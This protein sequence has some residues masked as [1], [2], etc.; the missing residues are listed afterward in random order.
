MAQ[1]TDIEGWGVD[2]A[3]ER[4]PGVPMQLT[5]RVRGGAHW[6]QPERQPAPD[7]RVFKRA[8]L[9]EL[10]PVFSTANP[11]HG[12]SGLL[13]RVAYDIPEHRVRHVALLLL[14]DRVDSLGSRLSTRPLRA[15]G[16]VLGAVGG[17]WWLSRRR[18]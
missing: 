10:T 2:E 5:P 11:P 12:L 14:A 18:A 3:P 9:D 16:V 4:R 6:K 15:L 7:V 17:G 8:E 1:H 13:R